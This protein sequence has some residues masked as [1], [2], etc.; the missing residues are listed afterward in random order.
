V[1]EDPARGTPPT[2]A[3]SPACRQGRARR[4]PEHPSGEGSPTGSVV[5]R[6]IRRRRRRRSRWPSGS[7][8]WPMTRSR[9]GAATGPRRRLPPRLSA[10]ASAASTPSTPT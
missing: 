6:R 1:V 3:R 4:P 7:A 5:Q 2:P 8:K 10:R 9:P